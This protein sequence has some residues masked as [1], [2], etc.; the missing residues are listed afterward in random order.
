MAAPG[1]RMGCRGPARSGLGGP[2]PGAHRPGQEEAGVA[3][4]AAWGGGGRGTTSAGGAGPDLA[5][6]G[7]LSLVS[8]LL[9][10]VLAFSIMQCVRKVTSQP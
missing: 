8:S 3:E 4:Q 5:G 2:G 6:D 10:G 9:S 1:H 7:I